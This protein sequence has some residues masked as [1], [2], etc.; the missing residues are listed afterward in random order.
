MQGTRPVLVEIQSLTTPTKSAFPKR[1]AQGIDS[2]R[3]EL[4]IAILIK[5]SSLPLYDQDVFVNVTGGIKIEENACDLAVALSIASSF[6]NKPFPA[7]TIAVGELGL[8]GEIREVVAL[9]KRIKEAKRLGFENAISAKE[10]TYLN[11]AI[12][13]TIKR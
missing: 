1:I 4:I 2:K 9:E 13:E 7:K 8:L 3:L 10:F 11:Q 5:R 12:K 6:Y